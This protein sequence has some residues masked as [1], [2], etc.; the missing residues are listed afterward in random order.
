MRF[1]H[2]L[3]AAFGLFGCVSAATAHASLDPLLDLIEERVGL[4]EAVALHKWDNRQPVQDIPREQQVLANVRRAAAE[5]GMD[6]ERAATFFAD[7]IETN[8]LMQYQLLS[9]WHF[10]EKAPDK[11]RRD[12]ETDIRPALDALQ[13]KLLTALDVFDHAA[14][15]RCDKAL[16][17]AIE[18]RK[19]KAVHRLTLIRA[20]A[21]LCPLAED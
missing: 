1:P 20:T 16:A 17:D 19:T 14:D 18:S 3:L 8:K 12:L 9:K 10:R 7:Q 15:A 6:P 4:A 11:P 5:Q 13:G 21:N 2:L